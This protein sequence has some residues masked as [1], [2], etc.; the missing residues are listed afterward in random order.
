MLKKG[1]NFP[2]RLPRETKL[3]EML[4]KA[5]R[6]CA[7]SREKGIKCK[8]GKMKTISAKSLTR[9]EKKIKEGDKE[10]KTNVNANSDVMAV[11]IPWVKTHW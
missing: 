7:F 8:M 3:L 1:V 11:P 5:N 2:Q 4:R 9:A 10:D 6:F